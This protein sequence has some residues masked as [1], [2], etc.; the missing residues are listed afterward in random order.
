MKRW[1]VGVG[2]AVVLAG[3]PYA[4]ASAQRVT[5]RDTDSVVVAR[6]AARSAARSDTGS[7]AGGEV[8]SIEYRKAWL[9]IDS[10]VARSAVTPPNAGGGI[11]FTHGAIT[12]SVG[13]TGSNSGGNNSN[14]RTATPAQGSSA[15]P[16]P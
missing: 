8:T 6:N 11:G 10:L 5:R 16:S 2:L 4:T 7:A 1:L 12:P 15:S 9:R 3:A 13:M 14:G